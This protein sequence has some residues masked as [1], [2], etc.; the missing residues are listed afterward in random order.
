MISNWTVCIKDGKYHAE[1]IP[2]DFT[3]ED[4]E[5]EGWDIIGYVAF[6]TAFDAIMYCKKM[7]FKPRKRKLVR[8]T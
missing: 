5:S 2:G 7:G 1:K 6:H 4:L 3:E 8:R